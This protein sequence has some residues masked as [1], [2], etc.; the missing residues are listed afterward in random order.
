MASSQLILY[1]KIYHAEA[2]RRKVVI[3]YIF[4]ILSISCITKI[5]QTRTLRPLRALREE[6][7]VCLCVLCELS[8]SV[9]FICSEVL[10]V[11]I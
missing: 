6:F 10:D 1:S 5:Y 2:Q 3:S 11:T 4:V 8:A 7:L 9:R